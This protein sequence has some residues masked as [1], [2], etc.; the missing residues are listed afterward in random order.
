MEKKRVRD[1]P[2]YEFFFWK[3]KLRKK[4][5]KSLTNTVVNHL[6]VVT[7][8]GFTNPFTT[9]GT[10][11]SLSRDILEDVLDCGPGLG[12]TTRHQRRTITSTFFTTR[13]TGTDE[14]DTLSF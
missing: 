1:N 14:K 6:D 8:T 13:D 10:I 3:K 7:G 11:G 12:V 4:T 2:D 5:R 9:W